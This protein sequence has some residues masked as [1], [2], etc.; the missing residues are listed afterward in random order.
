[1]ILNKPIGVP[2]SRYHGRLSRKGT[3]EYKSFTDVTYER[4]HDAHFSIIH[5][6]SVMRPYVQKH[7]QELHEKIQDKALIMK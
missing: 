3:K 6:L 1:M 4:V 7:L 2:L 5:Q